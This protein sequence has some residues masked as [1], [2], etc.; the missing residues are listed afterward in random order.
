MTDCPVRFH[1]SS[2][3]M[4]TG[5]STR[6]YDGSTCVDEDPFTRIDRH[7]ARRQGPLVLVNFDFAR[8]NDGLLR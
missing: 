5:H 7:R 4:T 3:L 6:F 1:D 8:F 2:M